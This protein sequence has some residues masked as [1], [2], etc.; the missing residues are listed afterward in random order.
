MNRKAQYFVIGTVAIIFV[1]LIYTYIGVTGTLAGVDEQLTI[2]S[3]QGDL[4]RAYQTGDRALTYT[5][6]AAYVAAHRAVQIA[7]E[8]GGPAACEGQAYPVWNDEDGLCVQRSKQLLA[9]SMREEL[10]YL[11]FQYPS[12][13]LQ[14]DNYDLLINEQPGRFE[15]IGLSRSPLRFSI[16]HAA[17]GGLFGLTPSIPPTKQCAAIDLVALDRQAYQCINNN[18][19]LEREAAA[20]LDEAR[21]LLLQQDASFRFTIMSTYRTYEQ[22]QRLYQACAPD[23]QGKVAQPSCNAPHTTGRA[24]DIQMNVP[25]FDTGLIKLDQDY[26]YTD[27]QKDAQQRLIRAMCIAGWVN[28]DKEW[29][30]FEYGTER[31]EK[32]QETKQCRVG[33]I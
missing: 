14:L 24:V 11:L 29:W 12:Q 6:N 4:V 7:A 30:H 5:D 21:Q 19:A 33:A 25:G 1:A 31:W 17:I 3:Y 32:G 20:K 28:Y 23:C 9:D 2:G 18:C 16:T 15:V 26:P 22:Q 27:S 10:D 13:T 8:T